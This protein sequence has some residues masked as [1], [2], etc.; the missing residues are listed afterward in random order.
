MRFLRGHWS[1]MSDLLSM[2]RRF[3]EKN[4]QQHSI[5]QSI[6]ESGSSE[7]TP[8]VCRRKSVEPDIPLPISPGWTVVYRGPDGRLRDGV[9]AS[10]EGTPHGCRIR[11]HDGTYLY[12][13]AIRGVR[14]VENGR[15]VAAWTVRHHGLNGSKC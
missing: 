3:L 14:Q 10:V 12:S 4:S 11:L 7:S 6:A 2:A 9:V 1:K 8:D 5:P 15:D 13:H